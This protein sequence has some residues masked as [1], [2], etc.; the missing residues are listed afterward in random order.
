MIQGIANASSKKAATNETTKKAFG[1]S[2]YL[3]VI[4]VILAKAV[5]VAPKPWPIRPPIITAESK[6]LPRTLK[7]IKIEYKIIKIAWHITIISIGPNKLDNLNKSM[8]ISAIVKNNPRDKSLKKSIILKFKFITFVLSFIFL[9][10]TDINIHPVIVGIII[11]VKLKTIIAINL[12]KEIQRRIVSNCSKNEKIL[13]FI[14][15][16]IFFDVDI[17][18]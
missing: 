7:Q 8:L 10:N 14:L 13:R 15:L 5:G 11:P 2:P 1:E 17:L 4:D 12:P 6:F 3:S 9:N 16:S 18:L